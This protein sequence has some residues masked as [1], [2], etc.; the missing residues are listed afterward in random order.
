MELCTCLLI[1]SLITH[2]GAVVNIFVDI[3]AKIENNRIYH[4]TEK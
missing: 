4:S 1:F 3:I 2:F